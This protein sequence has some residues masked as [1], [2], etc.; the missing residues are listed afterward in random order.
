M[1]GKTFRGRMIKERKDEKTWI[2]EKRK[3]YKEKKN[4]KDNK[5]NKEAKE[6]TA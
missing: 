4:T 5:K 3:L 6:I 1:R 2:K